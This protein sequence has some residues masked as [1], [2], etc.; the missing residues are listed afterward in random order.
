[1]IT[2]PFVLCRCEFSSLIIR[3]EYRLTVFEK[4]VLRKIFRPNRKKVTEGWRKLHNGKL[5]F[6]KYC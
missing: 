1:M 5:H 4:N 6:T 3:E 2:L